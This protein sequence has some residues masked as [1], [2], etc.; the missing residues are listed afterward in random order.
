MT[1]SSSAP[2]GTGTVELADLQQRTGEPEPSLVAAP[3]VEA[4]RAR[5]IEALRAQVELLD[6]AHDAILVRRLDGVITYWNKGAERMYG[7]RRE[8]AV[9]RASH[10]LLRTAFPAP[11]PAIERSLL[12]DG[13]W[14]GDLEHTTPR[15]VVTVSSRWVLRRCPS[16]SPEAVFEINNDITAR[17]A[18]EE[19]R[20]LQTALLRRQAQLLDLAHD[21]I[22]LRR[23]DGTITY[24]NRGAER[25][26]GYAAAEAIGARSHELLRTRFP[27]AL[28]EIDA[29]LRADAHW[30]GELEHTRRD[31]GSI[32]VES[33]WVA[34]PDAGEAQ[35]LVMEIN[36]DITARKEAELLRSEQQQE[37]IR[38]QASAIAELSTP[39]IPITDH[40]VVMPLIGVLD[41]RRAGQAMDTLL[42]GLSSS[43]ATVA[44]IDVTGVKIVDT[45]VADA[46][47]RVA[48]GARLLGAEV[49]L[50]GIRAE[51]AQTMVSLGVDLQ[52]IATRGT[53]QGGIAYALA[54]AGARGVFATSKAEGGGLTREVA[55]RTSAR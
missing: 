25:M 26:Y 36:T 28:S 29:A 30:Q 48:Q 6:V 37:L 44:I 55:P 54:R 27:A 4:E 16:G 21:A 51:V 11:L 45:K 32:A 8:D 47:L 35:A 53:L 43:G 5:E 15:G 12:E 14:E 22:V 10:E 7:I 52:G 17:K 18:A 1:S 13:H 31:G 40:V 9:G 24:W 41:T 49:V 19:E 46:L 3:A 23:F 39:L 20:D 33:R 42:G 50:T 34:Q 2:S 38:L